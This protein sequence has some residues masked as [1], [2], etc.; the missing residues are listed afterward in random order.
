MS[1]LTG[2]FALVPEYLN[3]IEGAVVSAKTL[4]LLLWPLHKFVLWF[5]G[6]NVMKF[7]G[8]N[9]NKNFGREKNELHI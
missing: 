4:I 7:F 2:L 8:E 6:K 5:L 1:N 3:S 9:S